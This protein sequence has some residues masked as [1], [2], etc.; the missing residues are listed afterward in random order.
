MLET[1]QAELETKDTQ[2]Q[3]KDAENLRL[4]VMYISTAL[5]GVY[6]AIMMVSKGINIM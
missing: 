4:Q 5:P 1:V 2:L 6:V 3:E